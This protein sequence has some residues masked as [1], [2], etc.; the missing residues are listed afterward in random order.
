MGAGL[1]VPWPPTA[2]SMNV[3][4]TFERKYVNVPSNLYQTYTVMRR[5]WVRIYPSLGDLDILQLHW[6]LQENLA[7]KINSKIMESWSWN[8]QRRRAKSC[9]QKFKDATREHTFWFDGVDSRA[10]HRIAERY[11]LFRKLV[12]TLKNRSCP[13]AI[14]PKDRTMLL[15]P[16]GRPEMVCS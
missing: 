14:C 13:S 15:R 4:L 11:E 16:D 9:L 5:G 1:A 6:R 2:K 7:A 8:P 3:C 12:P 10:W